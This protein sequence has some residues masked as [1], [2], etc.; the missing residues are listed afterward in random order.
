VSYTQ[1]DGAGRYYTTN[2]RDFI[3]FTAKFSF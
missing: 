1:F 2:D 3:G